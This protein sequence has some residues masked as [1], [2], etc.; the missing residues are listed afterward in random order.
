MSKFRKPQDEMRVGFDGATGGGLGGGRSRGLS[1]DRQAANNARKN[2]TDEL[3][4]L[5]KLQTQMRVRG[6]LDAAKA[7]PARKEAEKKAVVRTEGGVKRT[8][9]P[10]VGP[11]E[12]KKGG[13]VA[14]RGWGKARYK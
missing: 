10:Y 5:E 3:V 2:K 9:Y 14:P 4:E 12:Y 7:K 6:E 11:N 8:E 1:L 13:K